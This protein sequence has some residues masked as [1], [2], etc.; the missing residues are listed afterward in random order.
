MPSVWA[1]VVLTAGTALIICMPRPQGLQ[2]MMILALVAVTAYAFA[3]QV[4]LMGVPAWLPAAAGGFWLV[5][6]LYFV[7]TGFGFD[8]LAWLLDWPSS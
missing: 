2:G 4:D 1:W 7:V 5:T 8:L 6:I 3:P